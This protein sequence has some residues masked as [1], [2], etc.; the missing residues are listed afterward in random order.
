MFHSQSNKQG[1][2]NLHNNSKRKYTFWSHTRKLVHLLHSQIAKEMKEGNTMYTY[3]NTRANVFRNN[4]RK[5]VSYGFSFLISYPQWKQPSKAKRSPSARFTCVHWNDYCI[6][7]NKRA[8]MN[9][10]QHAATNFLYSMKKWMNIA[11]QSSTDCKHAL[12][13]H[14]TYSP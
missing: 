12:L 8:N 6:L 9:D 5:K 10:D 13:A 1:Q 2:W 14:T 11:K 3:M 7:H 4:C